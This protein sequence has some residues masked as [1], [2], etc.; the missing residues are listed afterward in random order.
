MNRLKE[1]RDEKNLSL[2]DLSKALAEKGI[3]IGRASLNNYER[4]E[5]E[6][7]QA[8][9]KQ[10]SDFFG[11]TLSYML[12][13]SDQKF[14]RTFDDMLDFAGYP[15]FN[16]E[17]DTFNTQLAS[18]QIIKSSV[19][20]IPGSNNLDFFYLIKLIDPTTEDVRYSIFRAIFYIDSL[21]IQSVDKPTTAS[22]IVHLFQPSKEDS[23]NALGNIQLATETHEN[24][25][26]DNFSYALFSSSLAFKRMLDRE[27]QST[28]EVDKAIVSILDYSKNILNK[29]Y[30]T[31]FNTNIT[32]IF[33]INYLN[34]I[35]KT[36]ELN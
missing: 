6:P 34:E 23:F 31:F 30:P 21:K 26:T 9:W 27:N 32:T 25:S 33:N 3:K 16:K 10:L 15:L 35:T 17:D 36:F 1:L 5:Q 28:E 22:L 20:N 4:G 19:K 8:T 7:K 24:I 14:K 18:F 29:K 2:G 11:V 13:L 12:G